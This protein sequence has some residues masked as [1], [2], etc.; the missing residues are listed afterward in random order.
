MA[1][2]VQQLARER[3]R[4]IH[5]RNGALDNYYQIVGI[6]G[7]RLPVAD[8][9]TA[10]T[11]LAH[12][13]SYRFTATGSSQGPSQHNLPAPMIGEEIEVTLTSTSTGSQQLLSTPNGANIIAS[14]LGTTVN[15]VNF[16]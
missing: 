5:G 13:G 14:S 7:V 11:T 9:G 4:P 8:L 3:V 2:T 1:Y 15:C 6:R 16:I 12:G 10:P